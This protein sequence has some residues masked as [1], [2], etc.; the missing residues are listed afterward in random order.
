[1]TIKKLFLTT[2][3]GLAVILATPLYATNVPIN[4]LTPNAG[5]TNGTS[6]SAT[7]TVN[8]NL[9]FS[10]Y[11]YNYSS[12]TVLGTTTALFTK[13]AV[14]GEIGLGLANDP[15]GQ[16]EI[17]KDTFIQLDLSGL[18]ALGATTVL[19]SVSSDTSTEAGQFYTST[20]KGILGTSLGAS[21]AV[22][23]TASGT[24]TA[25]TFMLPSIGTSYFIGLT[26]TT[27]GG[28]ILLGPS[29]INYT[30]S[31]APEPATFG[32]IG[33]ALLGLG[34]AQVRKRK[35]AQSV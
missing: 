5:F 9:T 3:S 13:N 2:I 16:T 19:L 25:Y 14:V 4:Y 6:T 18:R 28:N 22:V 20:T 33:L 29:S 1:M 15:S 17:T 26:E 7:Y 23:S 8:G 10:A 24:T 11:G 27:V 12:P 31:A 32:M 35:A 21:Y 30:P 34:A